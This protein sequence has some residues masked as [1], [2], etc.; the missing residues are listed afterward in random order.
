MD[1]ITGLPLLQLPKGFTYQTF[2]WSGDLM[3]DGKPTPTNHD[4]MAV[5]TC[6]FQAQNKIAGNN[7]D[8]VTVSPSG[9]VLLCEDGGGVEDDFGIG[10]RLMGLTPAG[11][12]YL[13]AKNNVMLTDADV[14]AASK[15]TEFIK[16]DDPRQRMGGCHIRPVGQVAVRHHPD[17]G[18]HIRDHRAMGTWVAV[19]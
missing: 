6:I 7:F 10:E 1:Q 4:G 8:N 18:D 3:I 9:G 11:E 5:V 16:A 15:S 17:P 14:A 13:F 2:G 19:I 12:T